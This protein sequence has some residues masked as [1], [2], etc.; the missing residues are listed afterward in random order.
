[1]ARDFVDA[2]S[3]NLSNGIQPSDDVQTSPSQ[4]SDQDLDPLMPISI[5]PPLSNPDISGSDIKSMSVALNTINTYLTILTYFGARFGNVTG[6]SLRDKFLQEVQPLLQL[7]RSRLA[8]S[9]TGAESYY[10][11]PTTA[12]VSVVPLTPAQTAAVPGASPSPSRPASFYPSPPA[13]QYSPA[14]AAQEA[15]RNVTGDATYHNSFPEQSTQQAIS[16][17]TLTLPSF[18]G[19]NSFVN[20]FGIQSNAA[21]DTLPG[22][23]LNVRFA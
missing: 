2:L 1:M 14:F 11:P 22:G 9:Q 23:T 20:E 16:D 6:G 21:W 12:A 4:L 18:A 17:A 13:S 10:W 7:L 19:T 5:Q 15:E 3:I 8:D